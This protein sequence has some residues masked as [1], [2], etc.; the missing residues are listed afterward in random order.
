[1]FLLTKYVMALEETKMR[2]GYFICKL[3]YKG[4]YIP[5]IL[6]GLQVRYILT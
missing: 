4:K 2:G 5:S 6:L 3:A 1:M